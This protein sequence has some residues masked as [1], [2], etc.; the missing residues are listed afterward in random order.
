MHLQAT[1]ITCAERKR[2]AK[3]H[4]PVCRDCRQK[5]NLVLLAPVDELL[6]HELRLCVGE[7]VRLTEFQPLVDGGFGAESL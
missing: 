2:H 4:H 1:A 5:L 7:S 6:S 3:L